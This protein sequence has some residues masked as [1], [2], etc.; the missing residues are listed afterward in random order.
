MTDTTPLPGNAPGR[1]DPTI[2]ELAAQATRVEH[3]IHT[4]RVL[5]DKVANPLARPVPGDMR[6]LQEVLAI[7]DELASDVAIELRTIA[8]RA[9]RLSRGV[10][11]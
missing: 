2:E 4:A 9:E 7:A 3:L 6:A 11:R 1:P 5:R 10:G 8:D